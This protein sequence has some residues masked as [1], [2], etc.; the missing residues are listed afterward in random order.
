MFFIKSSGHA[1]YGM[2]FWNLE[3]EQ[4]DFTSDE[5]EE[6]VV[7]LRSGSLFAFLGE[8]RPALRDQLLRMFHTTML[9]MELDEG[10]VEHA[11]ETRLMDLHRRIYP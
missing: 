5:F 7:A 9:E 3:G 1:E 2:V 10:D 4:I 8:R 11:L 6:L